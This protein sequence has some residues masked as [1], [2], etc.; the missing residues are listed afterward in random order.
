MVP[1]R[2]LV[3]LS[4]MMLGGAVLVTACG[5]DD[6]DSSSQGASSGTSGT[7][8]SSGEAKKKNGEACSA[9]G[10]GDA[11]CESGHCVTQGSGTGGGGGGGGGGGANRRTVCS[12]ECDPSTEENN[13]TCVEAGAPFSGRCRKDVGYCF[14]Q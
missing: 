14:V 10:T 5:G 4:A 13:P 7:S 11:E 6:D 3:V 12:I 1:N 8:G 9:A 2:G